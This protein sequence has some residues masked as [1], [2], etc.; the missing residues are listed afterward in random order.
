MTSAE[1]YHVAFVLDSRTA[2]AVFESMATYE[3]LAL[4]AAHELD[5]AV[6]T[7]AE[8]IVFGA[9][10]LALIAKVLRDRG[11]VPRGTSQSSQRSQT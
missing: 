6:A 8:S 7:A 3:L 2:F 5:Q 10:R 1:E 11:A 4:Q 9:G